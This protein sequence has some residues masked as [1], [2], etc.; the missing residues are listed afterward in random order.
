MRTDVRPPQSPARRRPSPSG[1][2]AGRV[3]TDPRFRRR[4]RAVERDKRRR[5]LIRLGTL[6]G[7][8]AL[9]WVL[10][11]SPLL[12]VRNV[13][14]VGASQTAGTDVVRAADVD[15]NENLLLLSG[16]SIVDRV[17]ALPWVHRARVDRMLPGT[18]R[19]RIT[20]RRPAMVLSLGAARWTIDATG[21][22]LE[23][24]SAAKALP[25]LAGVQVGT[26]EPGLTLQTSEAID[27]LTAY[28]S[29]PPPIKRRVVGVFAPTIE[30]ITFS[31][32]DET[33]IRYGAAED[34][35]AKND[36]LRAL[37]RKLDAE[38]LTPGYIDVRVPARPAVSDAPGAEGLSSDP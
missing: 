23:S 35:A 32:D 2:V 17:E 3:K 33:Q 24:G 37:L 25:V 22:V 11:M 9:G 27:A 10:F 26:I 28:R 36:V 34:I 21:R 12:A 8:V 13:E 19:I 16:G 4:R 18:L 29:L 5:V 14:V 1:R 20:E 6:I 38:G 30:R 31:L 15:E 7:L